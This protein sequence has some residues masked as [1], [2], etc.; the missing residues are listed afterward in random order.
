MVTSPPPR[1]YY[2]SRS[3]ASMSCTTLVSYISIPFISTLP[4]TTSHET[5]YTSYTYSFAGRD[6]AKLEC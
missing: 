4:P 3:L 6:A 2:S 1:V 5:M